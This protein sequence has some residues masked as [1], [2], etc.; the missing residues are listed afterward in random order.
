MRA[1]S[2][3]VTCFV[4][5]WATATASLAQDPGRPHQHTEDGNTLVIY[6]PQVDEW[7]DFKE[8]DWRKAVSL[9]HKDGKPAVG[10]G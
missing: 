5:I 8:L 9:T 7:K 3:V 10:L 4:I 2:Y 1:V 6:Q